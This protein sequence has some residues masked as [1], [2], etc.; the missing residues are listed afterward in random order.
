MRNNK[1]LQLCLFQESSAFVSP[2]RIYLDL[3]FQCLNDGATGADKGIKTTDNV[4]IINPVGQGLIG[5]P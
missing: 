5:E 2:K 3:E 1:V 4:S